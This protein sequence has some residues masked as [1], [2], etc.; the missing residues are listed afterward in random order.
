MLQRAG[1][2]AGWVTQGLGLGSGCRSGS[3]LLSGAYSR[4]S[5]I[6]FPHNVALIEQLA[7]LHSAGSPQSAEKQE[8]SRLLEG[9]A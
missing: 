6:G 9:E 7:S 8:P 5:S 2:P 4:G 1:S 3:I